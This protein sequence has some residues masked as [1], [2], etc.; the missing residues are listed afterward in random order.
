M[1]PSAE[2]TDAARY[3]GFESIPLRITVRVGRT[4]L[5]LARYARLEVGDVLLLD[6]S[7]G[8]PFDLMAGELVLGGVEPMAV[9]DGVG[10][11]LVSCEGPERAAV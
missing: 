7:V 3:R 8:T 10:F 1:S 4:R 5:S 6:R 2:V 9:A 11:K